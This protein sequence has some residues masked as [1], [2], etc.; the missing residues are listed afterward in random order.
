VLVHCAAGVGRTGSLLAAYEIRERGAEPPAAARRMLAVGPPSLE[1]ISFVLGGAK[2]PP[3]P[4]VV[5]S[6]VLDAPR[7]SWSRVRGAMRGH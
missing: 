2:P 6:R 7:R 3:G 1:Q 5:L 4:V